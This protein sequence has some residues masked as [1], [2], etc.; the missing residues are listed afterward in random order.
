MKIKVLIIEDMEQALAAIEQQL[1]R[2]HYQCITDKCRTIEQALQRISVANHKVDYYDLILCDYNMGEGTNGQQ[3]LEYLRSERLIPRKTAFI[4]VTGESAYSKVASAVELIPDGYLLKPFTLGSLVERID[5]ALEKREALK[6]AI[7]FMDHQEAPDYPAAIKAC[8]AVILAANKFALEALKL[9]SECLLSQE[10]W[11]EAAMVY[12]KIIAWRATPWAEVGLARAI[13]LMGDPEL[14]EKKLAKTVEKF[15]QFVSAYDELAALEAVNGNT[16]EA[17]A[18]LERA[19]AVVPSNRRTRE[20]GLLALQ[21]NDLEKATKFLKIVTER[22]RYGLKRS[23][24]DFFS[25]AVAFRKL[26]K[27]EEALSV[28]DSLKDHFP[29]TKPL[30]V[31][32]MAAQAN[33]FISAKRPFDAKR[34]ALDALELL[35]NQM[36]PNTQIELAEACYQSELKENAEEIFVHVAEN[37][38]EFP[39]VVNAV[40]TTMQ[41]VGMGDYGDERI[42]GSIKELV[43][44]NNLA[45]S[46]IRKGE[47]D[48]AVGNLQKVAKRLLRNATVQANYT[49]ALLLWIEHNSPKKPKDLPANSKPREY[50]M[51]AREHL[52]QLAS[53]DSK[54]RHLEGLRKLL[55]KLSGENQGLEDVQEF[56][57]TQ[58]AASMEKGR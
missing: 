38:Q 30:T 48:Q 8:N 26:G 36:D 41:R 18:T 11:S 14:A 4:M 51:L 24:E 55:S 31:R 53:I 42:E 17:Q 54:H 5:F 15:P 16:V 13:R 3:L 34:T 43:R 10:Q 47:Y 57:S 58:E 46:Q 29:D 27:H 28:I 45:A 49:Q 32:K 33:I 23:T 1:V 21:N 6:D 19:H 12:D 2:S 25:L 35:E 9:K 50:L 52:R 39:K 40:K 7:Q 44:L 56:D 37:W 22:D 20:L